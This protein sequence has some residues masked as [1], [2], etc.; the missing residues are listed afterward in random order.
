MA[1]LSFLQS[2]ASWRLERSGRDMGEGS[3]AKTQRRKGGK[4]WMAFL[5][6]LQFFAS[7]R[8][9]RS[10]RDMGEVSHAKTQRRKGGERVD[11]FSLFPSTLG[12]LSVLS[13]AGVTWGKGLTQRRR[14]AKG[15][16]E[17]WLFSFS[18]N[19]WRLGVLSVA[20]VRFMAHPPCHWRCV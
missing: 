16:K 6:F 3:H 5:S 11:G 19:P 15:K 4:G 10:G 1:F 12:V 9:E 2:F 17:C 18:F 20:G 8:L 14:D 13:V 7:W